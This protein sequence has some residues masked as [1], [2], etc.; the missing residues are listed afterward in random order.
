VAALP[1]D[2][3]ATGRSAVEVDPSRLVALVQELNEVRSGPVVVLSWRLVLP[4]SCAGHTDA[5][6][7]ATR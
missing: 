6:P 1:K 4:H 2:K 7:T 5:T 3:A